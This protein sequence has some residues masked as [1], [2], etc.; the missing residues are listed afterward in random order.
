MIRCFDFSAR[1]WSHCRLC[2]LTLQPVTTAARPQCTHFDT[3]VLAR[4]KSGSSTA[5]ISAWADL[6]S[7]P[8]RAAGVEACVEIALSHKH[9]TGKPIKATH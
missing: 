8:R 3:D 9:P 1:K 5:L 6:V 2:S 4:R 7:A